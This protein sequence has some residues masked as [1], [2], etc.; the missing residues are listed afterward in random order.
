M[1]VSVKFG[2]YGI[3]MTD[4]NFDIDGLPYAEITSYNS[5]TIKGYAGDYDVV[6]KGAG[7]KYSGGGISAGTIKSISETYH[8]ETVASVTGLN[9][10]VKTI[11]DLVDHGTMT[12][13]LKTVK[14][15]FAGADTISGSKWADVLVAYDG[16]DTFNGNGGN[17]EIHGGK[18][19]DRIAGGIGADK[20]FGEDGKDTFIFKSVTE[21]KAIEFDTIFDFNGKLGDRIDVH[22]IDADVANVGNQDFDWIGSKAFS[23][24]SGELRVVK[25]ASDT[26]I[27]GDTNGDKLADL[28]IHLDDPLVLS[29]GYFLL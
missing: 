22:A 13:V 5:T 10:S 2:Y 12:Q 1:S 21:S 11:I 7:F 28:V 25:G 24:H 8:G 15:Q 20:L 29:K 17:D 26:Y 19:N 27:Y 16:N 23:G 6:I 3:D 9:L 18:G 14:A 4:W